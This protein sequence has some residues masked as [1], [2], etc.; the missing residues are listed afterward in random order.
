MS[1]APYERRLDNPSLEQWKSSAQHDFAIAKAADAGAIPASTPDMPVQDKAFS[2]LD[3]IS[4]SIHGGR[5]PLNFKHAIDNAQAG[6][7]NRATLA[8]VRQQYQDIHA[9]ALQGFQD[10]PQSF[11]FRAQ[12]QRAFGPNH[13]IGGLTAYTGPAAQAANR[14]GTTRHETHGYAGQTGQS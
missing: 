11:P 13:N 12:I 3:A 14:A 4:N 6:L 10:T 7:G 9:L 5:S 1:Y 8:F 2:S